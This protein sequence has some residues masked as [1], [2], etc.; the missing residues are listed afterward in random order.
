MYH[1]TYALNFKSTDI[2]RIFHG[3]YNKVILDDLLKPTILKILDEAKL[4]EFR[5]FK[6]FNSFV[7]NQRKRHAIKEHLSKITFNNYYKHFI[8]T[9]MLER[10]YNLERF[11]KVKA[12]RSRSGVVSVTIFTAGELLGANDEPLN[13][14]DG[15]KRGGCPMN[16]HYCP[17]EKDENG[18][19]T[20]PRSYLST[21]PGNMRATQ[22]KHHPVAQVY[23]R[24]KS[25][26]AT[27]HINEY[28][29]SKIELII[30][31]GTF[32]F[33][34][35]KYIEWFSQCAYY[36]FNT[37]N[38]INNNE[39]LRDILSLEEEKNINV[40]ASHRVIG[41]TIETRPDYITTTD[42]YGTIDFSQ[43]LLFRRIGV[44]RVQIG[45]QSTDD[46]VLKK[47]NRKCTNDDNEIG[48]RRLK[49]NGFKTDIHIMLDLPYSTPEKDIEVL[50]RIIKEPNLQADQWKIYP[51]EVTPFTKIREWY[52]KGIY[53]PYAEIDNSAELIRVVTH[54]MANVPEYI[55]IN[56]VVRDIPHKSIVGGLKFSNLRQVLK[57]KMDRENIVCKDIRE[58][59]VKYTDFDKNDIR[60]NVIRYRASSG[61]E[62][63]INYTSKDKSKLYGF[64]RLRLNEETEDVLPCLRGY[65][66]IRELHVYG[67]HSPI[68]SKDRYRG[69]KYRGSKYR[70]T[71]HR[72]LGKKLLLCA[73]TACMV[74]GIDKIAVISGTG[75][76]N[77]Y[78][79][80]GYLLGENDY[81]YKKIVITRQLISLYNEFSNIKFLI[82]GILTIVI[83]FI[84]ICRPS[85]LKIPYC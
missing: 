6:D 76:R 35:D 46:L 19:P 15:I 29:T 18:V 77:Y 20:Q 45:V 70:G 42:K 64:I 10:N 11:L 38:N 53:K 27:G 47:I 14:E 65:G 83:M 30:S 4:K 48:I 51:T 5:S 78:T 54:A 8:K 3:E 74:Q 58:R 37:F 55:R 49:Q 73:E 85:F 26:G 39:K 63:F 28:D 32:N 81:M 24:L 1:P 56:R 66:L 69:S 34:P 7:T 17:F 75:V 71:Q 67:E 23:D 36:A 12:A 79:K 25:L 52:D 9:N 22:N 41:L 72:G 60:L 2:D 50:D 59:E 16:C 33:Y 21:E 40:T 43:I 68:D 61:T 80:R 44:T 57:N 82:Y 13:I 84:L 31:G 62:Y